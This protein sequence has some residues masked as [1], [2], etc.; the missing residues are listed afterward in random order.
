MLLSFNEFK[1]NKFKYDIFNMKLCSTE[2]KIK[3]MS[4]DVWF[5]LDCYHTL[6]WKSFPQSCYIS[7]VDV[8]YMVP[9]SMVSPLMAT[10]VGSGDYSPLEAEDIITK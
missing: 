3:N 9:V 5:L 2:Q 10:R 8:E 7:Q 6:I 4:K 1:I